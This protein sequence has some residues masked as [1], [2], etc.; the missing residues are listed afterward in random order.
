MGVVCT[1][2]SGGNQETLVFRWV[3]RGVTACCG[4]TCHSHKMVDAVSSFCSDLCCVKVP[5]L[6]LLSQRDLALSCLTLGWSLECPLRT[7]AE[8]LHCSHYLEDVPRA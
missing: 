5:N 2:S 1:F 6:H 3:T 7:I 4:S 8:V